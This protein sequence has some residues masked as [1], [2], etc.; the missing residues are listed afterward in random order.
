LSPG[1]GYTG[2]AVAMLAQLHPI[3]VVISAIFLASIYVGA[4]AMS[5][6][7]DIPNYIA[8]ILVSISLLSVLVGAMLTRYRIVW[9]K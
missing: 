3:G 6:T 2:I 5:R 1:F 7:I 4:D 8:D 9:G